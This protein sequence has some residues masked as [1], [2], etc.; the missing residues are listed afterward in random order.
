MNEF[1]R[2][3]WRLAPPTL[4]DLI[5]LCAQMRADE[6][7]QWLA[8]VD[9]EPFDF[10]R[11]AHWCYGLPG[12]KFSL[13][14]ADSQL[15]VAGGYFPMGNGIMRSW[16]VGTQASWDQY[17]RT[18]TEATNFFM[19]CLLED[20][21]RRLETY[22]LSS[23]ELTGKWYTKGCKMQAEGV[24]RAYGNGGENVTVY[25]RL[26]TAPIPLAKALEVSHGR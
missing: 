17:W 7:E 26:A 13:F 3:K 9:P 25:S 1:S 18:I 6:I 14:G 5:I 11:A 20:G 19:E 21:Y 10:E 15:L 8:L 23:R 22:A 16:M 2:T 24:L 12:V 4:R